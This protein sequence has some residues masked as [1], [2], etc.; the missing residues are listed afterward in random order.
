AYYSTSGSMF[1]I[2]HDAWLM[3]QCA[4][5]RIEAIRSAL[6]ELEGVGNLL[7]S[8]LYHVLFA[9]CLEKQGSIDEALT[10]LEAAVLHFERTGDLLWEPE[11]HRLMG[12]LHL[13]QNPSA[14][15]RAEASYLRALERA[16]SQEAKSWELRAA[17]SLARLWRDQGKLA[18]AGELLGPI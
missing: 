5:N 9:E 16:C 14:P 2:W 13:R 6:A 12:D 17:T 4:D 8:G 3:G 11:V 15:D 1:E 18:A 7:C 10:A